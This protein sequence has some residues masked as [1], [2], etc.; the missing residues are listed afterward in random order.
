MD[1]YIELLIKIACQVCLF[2]FWTLVYLKKKHLLLC[3]SMTMMHVICQCTFDV[4]YKILIPVDSVLIC[5][6]F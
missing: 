3:F 2:M 4:A 6:S 1:V 5:F